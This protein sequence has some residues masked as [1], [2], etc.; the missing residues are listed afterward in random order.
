[1]PGTPSVVA[2]EM[3]GREHGHSATRFCRER[4]LAY[5]RSPKSSNGFKQKPRPPWLHWLGSL[6]LAA[7]NAGACVLP[8]GR[9]VRAQPRYFDLTVFSETQGRWLASADAVVW[10]F[11]LG[12]HQI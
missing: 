4:S 2:R 7:Q 3:R 10:R 11:L 12:T 6:L 1:M 8:G 5:K 9:I